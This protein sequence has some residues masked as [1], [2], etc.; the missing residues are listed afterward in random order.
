MD[1]RYHF[2]AW[3]SFDKKYNSMAMMDT[4][5]RIIM[6]TRGGNPFREVDLGLKKYKSIVKI[7]GQRQIIMYPKND[8]DV[9]VRIEDL[10]YKFD[11]L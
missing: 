3:G 9:V 11:N 8:K 4:L 7:D 6:T 1:M 10:K 5:E 2:S